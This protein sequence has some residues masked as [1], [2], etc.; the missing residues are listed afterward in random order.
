[1]LLFCQIFTYCSVFLS[2]LGEREDA[3]GNLH[4]PWKRPPN[5]TAVD[6]KEPGKVMFAA[7]NFKSVCIV[8]I[9]FTLYIDLKKKKSQNC[10][11]TCFVSELDV[12]ERDPG[13]PASHR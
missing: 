2:A 10:Q 5:C 11:N 13:S 9:L 6:Q 1:M 7:V 12:A 3:S 4:G 8:E